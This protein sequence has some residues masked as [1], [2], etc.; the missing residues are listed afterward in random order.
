VKRCHCPSCRARDARDFERIIGANYTRTAATMVLIR[1]TDR[2]ISST[3]AE[4]CNHYGRLRLP[5]IPEW[6]GEPTELDF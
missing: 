2:A 1:E 5:A 3:V 6:E 4:R